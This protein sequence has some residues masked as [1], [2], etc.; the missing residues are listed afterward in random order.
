[1]NSDDINLTN[2]INTVTNF[3]DDHV[4]DTA[5]IGDY[6]TIIT[7]IKN[8][9]VLI[10]S[11]NI[12]AGGTTTGVTLDTNAI[13]NTMEDGTL[14]LCYGLLALGAATSNN[15]MIAAANFTKDKLHRLAKELV[16]D[17]C[18]AIHDLANTNAVALV[19]KGIIASDITDVATAISLYRTSIQNP[20]NKRV[21]IK[22]ANAQIH[23][24]VREIVDKLLV[25]QLDKL[26]L[27]LKASKPN[28]V[29]G[30]FIAREKID[31]GHG[32]TKVTGLAVAKDAD[33]FP[34]FDVLINLTSQDGEHTYTFKS[35]I[36]GKFAQ[37]LKRGVYKGTAV[38]DGYNPT[39]I[40]PFEIKQ[41]KTVDLKLELTK[42]TP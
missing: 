19:S 36:A 26:T 34:I 27:T 10:N 25:A 16:D 38:A 31:L 2:M 24:I 35:D 15:E 21:E 1:M 17:K 12:V 18:E 39:A 32:T 5:G 41:G 29:N 7:A 14:K 11:L 13:R 4:A 28:Y 9:M 37:Q 6:A 3:N 40:T 22:N 42:T 8:K 33:D 30:Y 20:R 23:P